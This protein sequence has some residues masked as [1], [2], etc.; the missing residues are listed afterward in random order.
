MD[1]IANS[2]MLGLKCKYDQRFSL[3]SVESLVSFR[4]DRRVEREKRG[5]WSKASLTTSGPYAFMQIRTHW[6]CGS[7]LLLVHRQSSSS[8]VQSRRCRFAF[9]DHQLERQRYGIRYTRTEISK[10]GGNSIGSGSGSGCSY[11]WFFGHKVCLQ[12][13]LACAEW[14]GRVVVYAMS[15]LRWLSCRPHDRP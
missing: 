6:F 1:A 10:S 5:A 4:T 7:S 8:R 14:C 12:L 2:C 9:N 13:L 15:L 11:E 3:L